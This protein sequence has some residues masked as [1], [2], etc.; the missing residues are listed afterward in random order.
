[1][2]R[3]RSK[4][5]KQIS[6]QLKTK[7]NKSVFIVKLSLINF[8]KKVTNNTYLYR[9]YQYI[10]YKITKI[11]FYIKITSNILYSEIHLY[12]KILQGIWFYFSIC[13]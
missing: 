10:L 6:K 13:K 11:T 5:C 1:M 3:T 9:N 12:G 2:N 4:N 7:Q 8:Y